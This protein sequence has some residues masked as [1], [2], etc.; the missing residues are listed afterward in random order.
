MKWSRAVWFSVLV[1]AVP[2]QALSKPAAESALCF[3]GKPEAVVTGE[4]APSALTVIGG[5]L[6]WQ[7]DAEL[8][9]LS[10]GVR[11][12]STVAKVPDDIRIF[13][14]HQAFGIT[15]ISDLFAVDLPTGKTMTLVVGHDR[16]EDMLFFSSLGLDKTYVYF[17]R[18]RTRATRDAGFFRV[19]R[20]GSA[21]AEQLATTPEHS[22]FIVDRGFVYWDGTDPQTHRVAV[23]RRE[24]RKDAPVEVVAAEAPLAFGDS[25]LRVYGGRLYFVRKGAIA[26]VPVD[27]RA[28]AST[29]VAVGDS[30]IR[31]FLTDGA[32]IYWRTE[33]AV[34]MRAHLDGG[35]P[36]VIGQVAPE[37][38]SSRVVGDPRRFDATMATD[39]LFLYWIDQAAG[40]IFRVGHAE[41]SGSPARSGIQRKP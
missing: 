1:A 35:V 37:D 23:L 30:T 9:R 36:E 17:T 33:A 26:S 21:P 34:I 4:I 41:T 24:L 11:K 14:L 28:A 15:R 29:A 5:E 39:T 13:D 27:G 3:G 25:L 22:H 20:D 19:R 18:G 31:D 12:A 7:A 16:M 2:S 38:D 6:V 40:K 8:R 10:P 32:C